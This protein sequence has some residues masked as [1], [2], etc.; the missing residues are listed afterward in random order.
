MKT[1]SYLAFGLA[2][3]FLFAGFY[4]MY[5]YENPDSESEYLSDTEDYVNAYV[6]GDAYNYIINAGKATANFTAAILFVIVGFGILVL[7]VLYGKKTY[8]VP[9]TIKTENIKDI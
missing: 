1:F 3:I 8:E 6:G 5:A 4:K 2:V 7:E 9:A